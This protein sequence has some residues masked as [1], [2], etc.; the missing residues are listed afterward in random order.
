MRDY[1]ESIYATF[2]FDRKTMGLTFFV[3][4]VMFGLSLL[5]ILL[6]PRE[7]NGIYNNIIIIQG[8]FIPFSCWCLMYRLSEMYEEGAQ[9]TLVPYYSK[10]FG[11]DF[12]RYFIVNIIG[13]FLLCTAFVV[14]YG[15][16]SL[17]ALNV[18]HFII[19]VLFYMFF[20]TSLIVLIKNIEI[21]LTIIIIYTVLEVVTLGE[22]MPWPHIFLFQ[23]PV[24]D[25]FLLRKFVILLITVIVLMFTTVIFIRRA[26]RK[27]Q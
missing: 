20:G 14:K 6:V 18:I 25:P 11:I 26:D 27:P 21:S 4:I 5:L 9:E 1:L 3:P 2:L 10:R 12:L 22:F 13:V 7:Q 16:S 15:M 8:V 23:P 24:W 19:L 17:S